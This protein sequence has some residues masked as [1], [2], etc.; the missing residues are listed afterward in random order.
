[1]PIKQNPFDKA[2]GYKLR[3]YAPEPMDGTWEKIEARLPREKN[4]RF[5]LIWLWLS[6]AVILLTGVGIYMYAPSNT[7]DSTSNI[8]STETITTTSSKVTVDKENVTSNT[9]LEFSS[10]NS[11]VNVD[12]K[13][14]SQYV[15]Q[16]Q[17]VKPT[18]PDK[19]TRLV[20]PTA[21]NSIKTAKQSITK[22]KGLVLKA[23]N[24]NKHSN[25]A[26]ESS[27]TSHNQSS[28]TPTD[29][30]T[31]RSN[32]IALTNLALKDLTEVTSN[33]KKEL[34]LSSKS[35][36]CADF[37]APSFWTPT[38]RLMTGAGSI[39]Y[40]YSGNDTAI[41]LRENAIHKQIDVFNGLRFS[42][43][44]SSGF[45]IRGGADYLIE[46]NS[47]EL[48]GPI[49]SRTIIDS[50]WQEDSMSWRVQ[51]R[52]EQFRTKSQIYNRVQSIALIAG[53]GYQ[54]TLSNLNVY[55]IG[56]LGYEMIVAQ[57]G[58]LPISQ[59][60]NVNLHDDNQ[61]ILK[62]NPGIQYGGILGVDYALTN[63]LSLG[64]SG[65]YKGLSSRAGE[66]DPLKQN[67][68]VLYGSLNLKLK[69]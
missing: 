62:K 59:D 8:A 45:I 67:R 24:V 25:L 46:R 28:V 3:N 7:A 52:N 2:Y 39:T 60:T 49:N 32:Q 43:E 12:T 9:H 10:K 41:E 6:A 61:M 37:S 34:G 69:L 23:T 4:N 13:K 42:L 51:S 21:K 40:N 11:S 5:G 1:M 16:D 20:T 31:S 33:Q 56:E 53:F 44:H 22:Q 27:T 63:T 19:S 18:T 54:Y 29:F 64:I 38:I 55:G 36:K 68:N 14:K 50:I 35:P 47:V 48:Y 17:E 30:A 15:L 57:R 66:I 58:I 65:H 26:V